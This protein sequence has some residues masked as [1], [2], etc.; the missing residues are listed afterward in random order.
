[1]CRPCWL[2]GW[3]FARWVSEDLYALGLAYPF[4]KDDDQSLGLSSERRRLR[5]EHIW[6]GVKSFNLTID[7]F[8]M[9][10]RNPW[11]DSMRALRTMGFTI[12]FSLLF[13]IFAFFHNNKTENSSAYESGTPGRAG[14]FLQDDVNLEVIWIHLVFNHGPAGRHLEELRNQALGTLTFK[15]QEDKRW[16]DTEMKRVCPERQVTKES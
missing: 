10:I 8:E 9:L 7:N 12:L 14:N 4:N 13:Y 6:G 11:Q 5:N 2:Q 15:S 1:M 3:D 16:T